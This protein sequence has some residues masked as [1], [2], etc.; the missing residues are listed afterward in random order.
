M[1]LLDVTVKIKM[2][3]I[4][5]EAEKLFEYSKQL[6][7]DFHMHPELGFKEFRTAKIIEGELNRLS[8]DVKT[9]V[10]DT[11]VVALIQGKDTGKVCMVRFDMD[12][13]PILEETGA[14]YAS[15]NPGVM[16]ACGHDA[17]VAIGLTVA[18][19]IA[20]HRDRFNGT[21][22]LV[23]QPA[24]EGLGGAEKMISESVLKDP[25]P[26][27]ALGVHVW[28]E[29]PLG[30][31]NISPGAV[32]AASEI[33]RVVVRGKGG[34]GALPSSTIDP[35]LAASEIISGLQSIVSRNVHPLKTAVISVTAVH[36]GQAFNVIPQEVELKGTIRTFEPEVRDLIIKR[37][38]Q[39]VDGL[40]KSYGCE[41]VIELQSLTPALVNNPWVTSI[42][43]GV[44]RELWSE[45]PID[46]NFTTMGSEDMAFFL[47]KIPGCF[48]FI[49]SANKELGFDA[50]HHHPKFD[51]D[52]RVL[53][54]AAGMIASSAIKLLSI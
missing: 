5:Q 3:N 25:I 43:Q 2:L 8:L 53:P 31:L 13:L 34:H 32:M 49:G 26:D 52:E 16:H 40:A 36:G 10:A 14:E 51:I 23:F 18:K 15:Q 39:I 27:F 22:K 42:V 44:A 29:A 12:A 6:R 24:E 35:I 54:M 7:R 30:W 47:E 50:A 20:A 37:F 41:T 17:H 19:L 45:V 4:L 38:S 48:I 9:G 11:G 28:N 46:T 1:C 33:F 21:I